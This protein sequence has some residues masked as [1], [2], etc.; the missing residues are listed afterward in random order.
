MII[1]NLKEYLKHKLRMIVLKWKTMFI[2]E[3]QD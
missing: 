2:S 3:W 1:N